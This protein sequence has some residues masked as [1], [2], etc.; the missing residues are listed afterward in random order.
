MDFLNFWAIGIGACALAAPV[1][2]HLLTK[3][4]PAPFALSTIRFLQEV[5]QQRRARS[6]LRDWLIL[7]LRSLC[8]ALLA[9]ALARPLFQQQPAVPLAGENDSQRIL[10]I[11]VSQSMSAGS[12]GVTSWSA[13]AASALQYLEN[14]GSGMSAAVIFAGANA[15]PVFDQLSP[16]LESLREAVKQAKPRAERAEPRASLEQAAAL[17]AKAGK[18]K[19]ELVIISDFQR[20]NWGTLLLDL[21][22]Q[23]TQ[24]QFHSVAQS[25][26]NNTSITSVRFASEPVVQQ[27]ATIEIELANFSD[28][29]S[30]VRCVLTLG[31]L[32]RT[33]DATLAPQSTR[34]LSESITFD[35]IGWK[36]GWAKLESNLDVLPDDDQRPVA[37]RVRSPVRVLMVTRQN[38]QEVPSS[39]FYLQ[40][41]LNVALVSK[42]SGSAKIDDVVQRINPSRLET[43]AWP[44]A[45][46]YVLDHP[47]SLST[48]S[49]QFVASQLRRGKGLLYVT[50]EL[51]DAINLKNIADILGSEFQPPVD[52][53]P[54]SQA[55]SRKDLFIRQAKSRETPFSILGSNNAASLLKMVRFQGG[56]GTR[57]TTEGLRDQILAELSDTSALLYIS[58]V[59][60]GQVAVLNTD[61]SRSNW[62]IQPTFLPIV[63]EL[64]NKLLAQR[65]QNE[66]A[67]CGEVAVRMLPTEITAEAK[68]L[69]RTVDGLPSIDG[70]FGSWQWSPSQGAVVWNW[71]KPSG[72]G[73]YSLED[74]ATPVWMI[75]TSAPSIES[76]LSSLDKEILTE[77]ISGQRE[78]G[79]ASAGSNEKPDDDIWKWM[80]VG[81]LFGL[82]AEIVALRFS[83]M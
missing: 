75:A 14:Q 43:R 35:E 24:V 59:G 13:A 34:T 44:Q 77:R 4:K 49:L 69:A 81:C 70:D 30:R 52:L 3:P 73:I 31:S 45:D 8:V 20:A 23:D 40:Q 64:I 38:V 36:H 42:Q 67:H 58:S 37:V 18:G 55:D 26:T 25:L 11:D 78:V 22:P 62:S 63:S 15:Y 27:P 53:V 54:E 16:N 60:A 1:A 7:L 29:E 57:A 50:A 46:V 2:V 65:G 71:P 80:I 76:D 41:A 9:M 21:I 28:Q 56:L 61:L 19:K 47:G 83:R 5:I 72:P 12:G 51:V 17:L 32:S 79:F 68:L 10:V 66:Q 82:I 33:F 39:S 74:N 48:E 6:R